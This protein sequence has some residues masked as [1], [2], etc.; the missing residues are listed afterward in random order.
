Q[1]R[2]QRRWGMGATGTAG[3]P[4]SWAARLPFYYGWGTLAVAVLAGVGPLPGRTGG[5]AVLPEGLLG[6]FRV[7]PG[8]SAG[9]TFWAAL[10][11]A[12]VGLPLGRLADRCGVRLAL[13]AVLLA[14]GGAVLLLSRSAGPL[15]LFLLLTL[16]RGLGQSALSAVSP[17]V[18]GKWFVRRLR[19]VMGLY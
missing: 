3:G 12:A 4:R 7:H 1:H 9:M 17:A 13:T 8:L 2:T 10:L 16:T 6:G 18:V 5:L 15:A 11:G 19:A 14:L